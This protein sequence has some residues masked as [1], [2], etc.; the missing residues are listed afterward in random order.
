[1]VMTQKR[2]LTRTVL[3]ALKPAAEPYVIR[4]SETP[5]LTLRVAP[6]GLKTWRIEYRVARAVAAHR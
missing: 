2:R 3:E 1:M 6:S 4:D 5:G